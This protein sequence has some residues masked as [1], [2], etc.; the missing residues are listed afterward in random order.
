MSEFFN[1]LRSFFEAL[2]VH[3]GVFFRKVFADP[4]SDVGSNFSRY[5]DLFNAYRDGFGF[6]GWLFFVLLWL[7][8]LTLIAAIVYLFIVFIK[9]Y[10]RFNKVEVEKQKL[11]EQVQRLNY[12]LY[13]AVTEKNKILNLKVGQLGVLPDGEGFEEDKLTDEEKN[14][15]FP[16][17]A[18][19]D[20]KYRDF[21]SRIDMSDVDTLPLDQL[22]A[23]FRFFAASQLGLYYE[24]KT[25]R[26]FFAGLGSS[27][28]IILEGISGTGKTSLPYALGKFFQNDAKIVSVQPSWRDRSELLGYYNEFTKKFNETDFLKAVYEATYREDNCVIVLDELNLARIEYYFAEFLSIMEMPNISEWN[29]ELINTPDAKTDPKHFKEGKLLIPQNVWFVGTANNDD[30]TFTITDKVY[31]RAISIFFDN[32]G[33]AFECDFTEPVSIT[34]EYLHNLFLEAQTNYPI[35]QKTL[36]KFDKLDSFVI[37]KFKIAFGNRILKQLKL[38]VPN[39]IAAGGNEIDA[40]DFIFASKI[41]KKFESLNLA[42]LREE[43]KELLLELDKLFGKNSFNDSRSVINNFLKLS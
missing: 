18:S 9:K 2:L 30:S 20:A 25:L 6:W 26:A 34:Y 29:I 21:D 14:S 7:I 22:V 24:L 42:F 11:V 17:L 5:A 12:E 10:L 35:S 40:L 16:K 41:L 32:K 36:D 13:L 43:L 37:S 3:T 27:K 4:W 33:Y 31:D 8:T 23:H 15:R 19:V 1:F 38:F 39:Y 28:V